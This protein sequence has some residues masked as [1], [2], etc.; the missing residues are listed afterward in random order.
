M[1][2]DGQKPTVGRVVP[3][4]RPMSF[5]EMMSGVIKKQM[6]AEEYVSRTGLCCACKKNPVAGS[7]DPIR[8]QSCVDEVEGLLKQLRGPGFMELRIG[9]K[10]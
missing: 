7:P 6:E 1:T 9:K 4:G 10:P 5:D 8:C 3:L 2:G